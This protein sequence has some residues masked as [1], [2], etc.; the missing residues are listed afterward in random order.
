MCA[1]EVIDERRRTHR[2]V[3]RLSIANVCRE[4]DFSNFRTPT[5]DI[6]DLQM[7]TL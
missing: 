1:S 7:N 3:N 6:I 2:N 4:T 5:L